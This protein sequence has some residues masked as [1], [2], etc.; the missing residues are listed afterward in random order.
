MAGRLSL[1]LQAICDFELTLGNGV[2]RIDDSAHAAFP[3]A[4]YLRKPLHR[5]KIESTL[6]IVPPIA[7]HSNDTFAGYVSED[8]RQ[9]VKG[10]LPPLEELLWA[11]L[12]QFSSSL[13]PIYDLERSLGNSVDHIDEPA[14]D[15]CP[16]AIVFRDPVHRS[17]VESTLAA[18]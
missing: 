11:A 18:R 5:A 9:S 8:T 4:V 16:L 14:G 7:W 13:R 17:E 12:G 3:L 1:N 6:T 15:R 2:L 10:P